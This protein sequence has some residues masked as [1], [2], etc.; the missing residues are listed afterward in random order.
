MSGNAFGSVLRVRR[1]ALFAAGQ[2]VSQLG[3]KLDQMALLAILGT[4]RP[5]GSGAFAVAQLAVVFALPVVL[6]G[7]WAGVLVDRWNR[8]TTLVVCDVLRAGLVTLIPFAYRAAGALWAVYPIVFLVF[9]LGLVFNAAKM[10]VIPDLVAGDQLLAANAAV[11]FI[12]RFATVAGIVG[13]GL[14]VGASLWSSVGWSGYEAGFYLDA[15]SFA[16]SA[17]TLASAVPATRVRRAAAA[18]GAIVT[19]ATGLRRLTT[20]AGRAMRELADAWRLIAA[21]ADL[22]FVF[23]TVGLVAAASGALYVLAV[24]IVQVAMGLG[25][26]GLGIVGGIGATG[27]IAGSY[28]TGALGPRWPK[29]RTILA[30]S[31]LAG[32]LLAWF[33]SSFTLFRV[34]VAAFLVGLFAAPILISQDTWLHQV[35]PDRARGRVFAFRD[36][37]TN[38][39]FAAAAVVTAAALAVLERNGFGNPPG[40]VVTG[41]GGLLVLL[42]G[43]GSLVIPREEGV[44]RPSAVE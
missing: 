21:R 11:T 30:A 25:T 3:D 28:L 40:L 2:T 24:L 19:E 32:L 22:R 1:F 37:L 14:V 26:G 15:L 12:G 6:F 34:A 7:P 20:G 42:A 16:V 29:G 5:G 13:G 36:L 38:G 43:C 31:A 27:M 18:S 33:G 4:L 35:L 9:L 10:S 44:P 39:A 23:A 8:R 17:W 41:A